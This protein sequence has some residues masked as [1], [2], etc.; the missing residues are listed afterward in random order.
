MG[1]SSLVKEQIVAG[2]RLV[3]DFDKYAKLQAAFWLKESETEH[4]YLYLISD[5]IIDSN[6]DLAYQP[7]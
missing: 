2:S 7:E 3:D 4:L 6:F 1:Q 5:E